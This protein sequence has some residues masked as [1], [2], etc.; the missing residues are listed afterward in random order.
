M[1]VIY[2]TILRMQIEIWKLNLFG[3]LFMAS[4]LFG[5]EM[6]LNFTHS[7]LSLFVH[8]INAT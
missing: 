3:V 6:T 5:D 2:F 8:Q 4:S 1:C 7:C